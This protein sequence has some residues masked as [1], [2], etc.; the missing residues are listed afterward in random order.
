MIKGLRFYQ[1]LKCVKLYLDLNGRNTNVK[2][3]QCGNLNEIVGMT[4]TFVE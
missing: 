4:V 1:K 2:K 3:D